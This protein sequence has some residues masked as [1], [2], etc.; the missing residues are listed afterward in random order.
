M[1]KM[2]NQSCN[3]AKTL[4]IVGDR[5]T[6]LIVR[7][8]LAGI[9]KF[10]ELKTSLSGIATNILSDRLQA[11]ERA[12]IITSRLYSAHPPRY[13]YQLTPRGLELRH[14]LN[15]L[16]IWGNRYL[17][18]TYREI[19]H[20]ECGHEVEVHYRCPKCEKTIDAP[21]YRPLSKKQ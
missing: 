12:E 1:T 6:L 18:E 14:V 19:V 13:E 16:G 17:D 15:A 21:A 11:L 9:N 10:T 4:E 5:W 8:L 3:I 7:D 20:P 2:Y